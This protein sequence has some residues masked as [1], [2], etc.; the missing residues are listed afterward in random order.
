MPDRTLALEIKRARRRSFRNIHAAA[1]SLQGKPHDPFGTPQVQAASENCARRIE[2]EAGMT[3]AQIERWAEHQLPQG[4]T[5]SGHGPA[6]P[7]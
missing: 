4:R 7:S 1:R 2:R 5:A 3:P 6:T